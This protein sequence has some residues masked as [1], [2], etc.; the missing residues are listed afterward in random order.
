[1]SQFLVSLLVD[2]GWLEKKLFNFSHLKRKNFPIFIY[3]FIYLF[4]LSDINKLQ[5]TDQFN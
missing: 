4:Y 5:T 2:C 3:L 1:M